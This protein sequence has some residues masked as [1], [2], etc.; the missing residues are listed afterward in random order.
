MT[1]QQYPILWLPA[2]HRRVLRRLLLPACVVLANCSGGYQAPVADQSERQN[3]QPPIIM[4]SSTDAASVTESRPAAPGTRPVSRAAAGSA[5]YTSGSRVAGRG[6]IHRVAR[7]ETLYSIAFQHELDFRSLAIANNLQAPYTI[8]V[9]QE[10]TLDVGGIDTPQVANPGG[11]EGNQVVQPQ[12][13]SRT[14]LSIIRQPIGGT[15]NT[16]PRWEWPLQGRVV[17]GFQPDSPSRKGIDID[18]SLGQAVHAAGDGDVVY[19]GNGVQGAG[20]LII[21][22]HSDRYLSAYAHNSSLLVNEG[23]RVRAGD[24]IAEVGVNSAGIPML[25]FEIR[26][27]GKPTDPLTHLP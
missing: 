7:G 6:A 20:D 2:V 26:Q 3:R 9:N 5:S 22:R 10:L 24:K 4:T 1:V 25:H 13:I 15:T 19:A 21:I 11:L 14:P 27:D 8:Y 12:A 18:A 16:A 23:S 17:T